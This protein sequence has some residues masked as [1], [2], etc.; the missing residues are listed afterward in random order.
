MDRVVN[1]TDGNHG[2]QSL[3]LICGVFGNYLHQGAEGMGTFNGIISSPEQ[4]TK[5]GLKQ[6]NTGDLQA[7]STAAA[8]RCMPSPTLNGC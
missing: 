1:V 2:D 3:D 7:F 8:L 5:L 4:A 6:T